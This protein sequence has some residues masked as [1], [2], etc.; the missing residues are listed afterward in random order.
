MKPCEKHRVAKAFEMVAVGKHALF[1]TAEGI[2]FQAADGRFFAMEEFTRWS[3][4]QIGKIEFFDENTR[5]YGKR[6]ISTAKGTF[7]ALGKGFFVSLADLEKPLP[8]IRL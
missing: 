4:K 5:W 7:V 8:R 2:F 1:R 6:I 3:G